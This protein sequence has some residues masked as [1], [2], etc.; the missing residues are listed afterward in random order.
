M[1]WWI[2][3]VIGGA[4]VVAAALVLLSFR[5][6]ARRRGRAERTLRLRERFG[7]EYDA[8]VS[9]RGRRKGERVLEERLER[10]DGVDVTRLP[11]RERE[12]LTGH[13]HA[14][15]YRFVDAPGAALREADVL[16]TEVVRRRG[17][18][19]DSYD[20]R[21]DVV[22]MACPDLAGPYR[23]AHDRFVA[24]EGGGRPGD[25]ATEDLRRALLTYRALFEVFLDRPDSDVSARV[26]EPA[27]IAPPGGGDG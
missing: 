4:V 7:P 10:L 24:V 26:D 25:V 8:V 6:R 17:Y 5:W 12:E 11:P 2:W 1:E 16:V 23:E 27:R 14:V 20:E 15:Q 18:P 9:D 13:W 21:V 19:A 22:A 3:L